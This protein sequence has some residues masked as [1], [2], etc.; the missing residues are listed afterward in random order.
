MLEGEVVTVNFFRSWTWH[1]Y[2]SME[3]VAGKE[4]ERGEVKGLVWESSEE[5]IKG[6]T[7]RRRRRGLEKFVAGCLGST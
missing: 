5:V 7:L 6:Q 4:G 1:K 2:A 3:V